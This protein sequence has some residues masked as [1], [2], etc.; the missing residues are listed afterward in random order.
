MQTGVELLGTGLA[1]AMPL[2]IRVAIAGLR[3]WRWSRVLLRLGLLRRRPFTVLL[4]LR[5]TVRR[6]TV[7]LLRR[8]VLLLLRRTVLLLL[9]RTVLLLLR[10]PILRSA[11]LLLGG[12]VGR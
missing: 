7:L 5:R 10:R 2:A 3:L 1:K 11:V 8:T 9:R 6:R 4:L 12:V